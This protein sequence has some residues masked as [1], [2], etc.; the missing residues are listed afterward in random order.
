MR[1]DSRPESIM[2]ECE[3]SLKRLGVDV[4]D[5]YQIHWPDLTFPIEE[6]LRAMDKLKQA[7]KIRCIGVSNFNVEQMRSAQEATTIDSLQPPYSLLQR[8]IE[9]SIVPTKSLSFAT[10]RWKGAS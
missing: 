1:S 4:I 6:S 2:R 9:E 8:Q 3:Q 10:P 7:G 5:L